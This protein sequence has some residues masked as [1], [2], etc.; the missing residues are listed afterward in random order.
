MEGRQQPQAFGMREPEVD[1]H[2]VEMVRAGVVQ[3]Q[4]AVTEMI[5][6]EALRHERP[7]QE[8]AG[9]RFFLHN[10]YA[11]PSPRTK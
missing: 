4:V 2:E 3:R 9:P 1:D 11:H 10:Q 7:H 8:G 6:R 5:D